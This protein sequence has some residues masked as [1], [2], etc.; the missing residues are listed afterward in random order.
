[1]DQFDKNKITLFPFLGFNKN[2]E[3]ILIGQPNSKQAGDLH[4]QQI[5]RKSIR[6]EQQNPVLQPK[7]EQKDNKPKIFI[8]VI[9]IPPCRMRSFP[10]IVSI[11]FLCHI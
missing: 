7:T 10:I 3:S 6:C 9:I 2:G 8:E 11:S 1:M 5:R 4:T